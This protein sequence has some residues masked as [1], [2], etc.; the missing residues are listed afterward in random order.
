MAFTVSRRLL[1]LLAAFFVLTGTTGAADAGWVTLKNDTQR[2]VVIQETVDSHGQ[3]KRCKP[4]RLLPGESVREFQ[5][6]GTVKVE[7]FDAQN[8]GQPLYAGE[9]AVKGDRQAF[10]VG[11]DGKQKVVVAPVAR[12]VDR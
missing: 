9:L 2:V 7:V 6:A 10:A 4:V 12:R 5:P 8:P 1:P 11:L 3:P